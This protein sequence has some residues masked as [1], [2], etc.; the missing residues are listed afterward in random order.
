MSENCRY[1]GAHIL[2]A[3]VAGAAAGAVVALLT[4]PQSGR[5]TREKVQ[6]WAVDLKDKAC[7][8]PDATREALGRATAAAK[9]AFAEALRE[10]S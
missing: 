3:F 6:A 5:E 7:K 8:V 2:I 10:E 1:S 4:A 9:S